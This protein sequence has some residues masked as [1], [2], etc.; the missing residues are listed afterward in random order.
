MPAIRP[1]FFVRWFGRLWRLVDGT[2]RLL[3]NLL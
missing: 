2:R 1:G 3:L